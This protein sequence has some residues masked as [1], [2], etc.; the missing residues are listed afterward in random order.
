[1]TNEYSDGPIIINPITRK[2]VAKSS[3]RIEDV[4]DSFGLAFDYIQELK[5][6]FD[7][8]P[9]KLQ[10]VNVITELHLKS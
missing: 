6:L 8:N 2:N 9:T 4:K 3:F 7:K 10:E 5:L 1:M